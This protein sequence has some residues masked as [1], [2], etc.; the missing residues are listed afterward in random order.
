[1]NEGTPEAMLFPHP[2]VQARFVRREKRFLIHAELEGGTTVIAHTNNTGRMTGCLAPGGRVWL[3]P[4]RDPRRKLAWTLEITE[5][6]EG[7]LV[8]VNTQRANGLVAEG[9]AAGLLPGLGPQDEI[10]AEVTYPGG[11]SRADFLVGGH[12]WIEVKNA[13]L[14]QEGRARFPDA[15]TARGR[16][17]LLALQERVEGGEQAALVFCVQRADAATAGPADDIDPGYG[18]LLRQVHARGV[19]VL[20]LQIRVDQ[21][22]LRPDKCL[23]V[24]L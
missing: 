3:S 24:V 8:G 18:R 22:E 17:H 6:P 16:K 14:V 12:T 23:P 9:I 5:T 20:A 2:L 15:P 1:M 19:T 11:K 13:T 21:Q 7:V 10:R 4:A